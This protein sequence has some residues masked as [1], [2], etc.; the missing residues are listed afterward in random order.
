MHSNHATSYSNITT[1]NCTSQA[2]KLLPSHYPLHCLIVHYC[3]DVCNTIIHNYGQYIIYSCLCILVFSICCHLCLQAGIHTH[4]TVATSLSIS[5]FPKIFLKYPVVFLCSNFVSVPP[6]GFEI[7]SPMV[8]LDDEFFKNSLL[9][10]SGMHCIIILWRISI[11]TCVHSTEYRCIHSWVLGVG[12]SL[13]VHA[14]L[15]V[16]SQLR[17]TQ[18]FPLS[19]VHTIHTA[20]QW[21][22][23]Q[24]KE[25][26][27]LSQGLINKHI[28]WWANQI[29]TAKMN[30]SYRSMLW[31][32]K[33][34]VQVMIVVMFIMAPSS[35]WCY[36]VNRSM[37]DHV[38]NSLMVLSINVLK[39][40]LN[41]LKFIQI[42]GINL[43]Q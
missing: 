39:L 41:V 26:Y 24:L 7:I 14:S 6:C 8:C 36:T 27:E 4:C 23:D 40:F 42:S 3:N 5:A 17:I 18:R 2:A 12:S 29:I 31:W 30:T 22:S 9:K 11:L 33:H 43:L 35:V 10:S 1:N 21:L 13:C 32:I 20:F 34:Y 37:R 19:N 38:L 15:A 16:V 25:T 28:A